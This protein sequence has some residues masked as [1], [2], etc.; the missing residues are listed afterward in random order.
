M[1]LNDKIISLPSDG[2]RFAWIATLCAGKFCEEPGV[3]VSEGQWQVSLGRRARWLPEF[4]RVGLMTKAESG[5]IAVKNW[6]R[7]QT[8][9]GVTERV[10]KHRSA[11]RN[12]EETV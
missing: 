7:W 12:G 4:V 6:E 2:A 3:W 8:D 1:P 11:L 10:R 9:P 5:R